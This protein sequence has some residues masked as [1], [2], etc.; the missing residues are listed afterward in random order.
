[1]ITVA[2][3]KLAP[4]LVD[5][6]LARTSFEAQQTD[7]PVADHR[8]DNLF[9]PVGAH[10][11]AEGVFTSEAND[12]SLH[13]ELTKRRSA[14]GLAAVGAAVLARTIVRARR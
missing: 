10:G 6:Y 11:G 2:A 13:F 5:R 12:R 1:M 7:E 9:E 4:G 14:S 8:P 3:D